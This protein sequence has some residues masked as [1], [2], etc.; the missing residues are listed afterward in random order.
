MDIKRALLF[1][2]E[3]PPFAGENMISGPEVDLIWFIS[4]IFITLITQNILL[5]ILHVTKS[6]W[7]V[8]R[9]HSDGGNDSFYCK[10]KKINRVYLN[11][12]EWNKKSVGVKT[13]DKVDISQS[14]GQSRCG[15][16]WQLEKCI[17][18]PLYS[19][20]FTVSLNNINNH[21]ISVVT[22]SSLEG[23]RLSSSLLSWPDLVKK[24]Y[25]ISFSFFQK[26]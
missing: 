18:A 4:T 11:L 15:D 13:I 6:V 10:D 12:R 17:N 20:H 16:W 2:S 19:G 26:V 3:I 21:R 25:L 14:I 7:L 23:G 8:Y 24:R 22:K 9:L 1:L 5:K